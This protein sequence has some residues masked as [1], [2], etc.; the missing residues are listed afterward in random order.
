[1][2]ERR[3]RCFVRAGTL[4]RQET[5]YHLERNEKRRILRLKSRFL[6]SC[7]TYNYETALNQARRKGHSSWLFETDDYR[8]WKLSHSPST[9]LCSGIVGSGKTILSSSVVEELMITKGADAT[10]GYFFCRYDDLESLKTREIVGSLAR[11]LLADI[12]ER[13]F[14]QIERDVT[15]ITLSTDQVI[16]HLLRLLPQQDKYFMLLDGLDECEPEEARYLFE[17]L[18]SLFGCSTHVFKLFWTG[19]SD[20]I[21]KVPHRL[22]PNYHV[23]IT[24]SKNE[25][26][27][28]NLIER[29]LDEALENGRLQ[30]QDPRIIVNIQDA[31]EA[32]ACEMY[33][34][35]I[36]LSLFHLT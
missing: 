11:Q 15:G 20:F 30:L 29:A 35:L 27:I 16:S 2:S 34:S 4:F 13:S 31:L 33:A 17:T 8:D 10:V 24:A 7:S 22:Q 9:L 5:V 12:P 23:T 18:E 3:A 32:N 28:S 14:N 36:T 21:A 26:E 6:N 1:M 25:P 19:R